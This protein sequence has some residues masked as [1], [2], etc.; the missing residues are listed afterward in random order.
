MLYYV[1]TTII[2]FTIISGGV[3]Y[4]LKHFKLIKHTSLQHNPVPFMGPVMYI[5]ISTAFVSI[6][7]P[8]PVTPGGYFSTLGGLLLVEFT[9]AI[10][11]GLI[12]YIALNKP[13]T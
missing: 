4:L 10:C 5:F 1:L 13:K 3:L 11:V 2:I 6:E 12:L 8:K 7:T 9:V